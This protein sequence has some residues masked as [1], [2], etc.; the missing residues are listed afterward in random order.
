MLIFYVKKF[1]GV[2]FRVCVKKNKFLDFRTFS[3]FSRRGTVRSGGP[4]YFLKLTRR[5]IIFSHK[6]FNFLLTFCVKIL[7]CKILFQ[8][9]PHL[10]EKREGSGAGSVPLSD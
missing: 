10:G 7:F 9:A 2:L 6:K 1:V 5:Q 4:K 8:S 3:V